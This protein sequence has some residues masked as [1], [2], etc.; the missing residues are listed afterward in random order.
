M[1]WIAY[2]PHKL[3]PQWGILSFFSS[4]NNYKREI[5]LLKLIFICDQFLNMK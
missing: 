5:K 4:L 1:K 2:F 3:E